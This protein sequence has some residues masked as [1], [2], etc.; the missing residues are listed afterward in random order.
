MAE[1]ERYVLL[2]APEDVLTERVAGRRMDPQTGAKR[3]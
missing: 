2:D 3:A 1:V